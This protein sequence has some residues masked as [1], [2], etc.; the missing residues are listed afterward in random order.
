MANL[1]RLIY[2]AEECGSFLYSAIHGLTQGRADCDGRSLYLPKDFDWKQDFSTPVPFYMRFTGLSRTDKKTVVTELPNV[3][4]EDSGRVETYTPTLTPF[5]EL[6]GRFFVVGDCKLS[7][8]PIN[9]II[10]PNQTVIDSH[11][12]SFSSDTIRQELNAEQ[13]QSLVKANHQRFFRKFCPWYFEQNPDYA[14]LTQEEKL[15]VRRYAKS[16]ASE[17]SKNAEELEELTR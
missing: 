13:Y 4:V 5:F 12:S 15:K 8:K 14:K 11:P 1:K 3:L 7:E 17:N 16:I 6:S 10:V 9:Q 2:T